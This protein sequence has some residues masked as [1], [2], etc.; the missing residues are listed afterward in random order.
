[1]TPAPKQKTL[2]GIAARHD[3]P[4]RQEVPHKRLAAHYIGYCDRTIAPAPHPN[5]S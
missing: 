1:M 4:V 3:Q 5:G 2:N